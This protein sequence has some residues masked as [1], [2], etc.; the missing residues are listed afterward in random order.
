MKSRSQLLPLLVAALLLI[1]AAPAHDAQKKSKPRDRGGVSLVLAVKATGSQVEQSVERASSVIVKRCDRLGI[2]CKLEPQGGD[3]ANQLVLRFSTAMDA[4][5]V[6]RILLAEGLELRA[7][8]SPPNPAPL[9]EY[10]TRAEALA[11]AGTRNDVFAFAAEE[12][13][14]VVERA[15]IM[16]GDELRDCAALKSEENS[17]EYEVDCQLSPEGSARLKDWTGANLKR[18]IAVVFNGRALSAPY[19]RAQIEYNIVL[20]GGF[21]KRDAED[22]AVILESGNLPAPVE[23]LEEATYRP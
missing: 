3:K 19:I 13:Y 8:A 16:T 7:V 11:A 10:S 17:A 9:L 22:A 21:D 1:G 5:R 15:P 4:G 23:V 12:T 18:Y 20:Q 2:Y 6:K 14:L